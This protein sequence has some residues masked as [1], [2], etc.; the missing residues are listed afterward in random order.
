MNLLDAFAR[1]SYLE[2]DYRHEAENLER[3][4]AELVPRCGLVCAE[5]PSGGD[6]AQGACD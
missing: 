1:A 3:F 4:E 2:L 6:D 5:V